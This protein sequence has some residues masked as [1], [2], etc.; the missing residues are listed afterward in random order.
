MIESEIDR[1][2]I[3]GWQRSLIQVF[4]NDKLIG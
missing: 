2:V 1:V 3:Y 4:K